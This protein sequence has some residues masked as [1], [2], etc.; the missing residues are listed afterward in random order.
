MGQREPAAQESRRFVR[1]AAIEGH[2]C[3]GTARDARDLG[4]PFVEAHARDFDAVRASVDDLVD[5]VDVHIGC[6]L[7]AR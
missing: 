3:G 7:A 1:R 4:P 5:S 2:R 6:R